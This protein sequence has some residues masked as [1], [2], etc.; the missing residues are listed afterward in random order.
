[1]NEVEII[2][3]ERYNTPINANLNG[4]ITHNSMTILAGVPGGGKST[5]SLKI[6]CFI[7]AMPVPS[8]EQP[9]QLLYIT[10]E[11][12]PEMIKLRSQL[13][14]AASSQAEQRFPLESEQG[15]D[16]S[17]A[18]PYAL[19]ASR[20]H[21]LAETELERIVRAIRDFL[22]RERPTTY[23]QLPSRSLA[24]PDSPS[25]PFS[26]SR[27]FV[28][29]DSINAVKSK[30]STSAPGSPSNIVKTLNALHALR[31]KNKELTVF[32]VGHANKQGKIAGPLTL[33]HL[34][35]TVLFLDI[36]KDGSTRTLTTLKNRFG[37]SGIKTLID[38]PLDLHT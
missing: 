38:L 19:C 5:I 1:M 7:A 20:I 30:T 14:N 27:S 24:V 13:I 10:S 23:D 21:L 22:N 6:L 28:V 2:D 18:L 26:P 8:G 37:P 12:G 3:H 25:P 31:T 11:E 35:D 34:V 29:L 32:I 36:D 17:R 33:Q 16:T 4:G 9:P 15:T